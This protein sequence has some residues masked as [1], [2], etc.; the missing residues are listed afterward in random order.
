MAPVSESIATELVNTWV[1]SEPGRSPRVTA[2]SPVLRQITA[3]SSS[4]A[5]T[6][7]VFPLPHSW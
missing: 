4:R 3:P 5:A 2:K 7:S 6:N 1:E